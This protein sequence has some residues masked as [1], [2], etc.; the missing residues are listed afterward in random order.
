MMNT[1]IIGDMDKK[2]Q[3]LRKLAEDIAEQGK[4]IESVKRNTK[5]LLA[6]VKMLELNICDINDLIQ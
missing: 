6:S 2:I 5:R 4:E 3:N 1:N